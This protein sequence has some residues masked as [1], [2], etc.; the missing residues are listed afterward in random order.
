MTR[1][2][3]LS[4]TT[5]ALLAAACNDMPSTSGLATQL[6]FTVQP[7]S[8]E[9]GAPITVE[10]T[11]QDTEGRTVTDYAGDVTLTL[12]A[13]PA[14]GALSGTLTVAAV[15]GVATF[16]DVSIAKAGTSYQLQA[17]SGTIASAL[18]VPFS[19]T[20]APASQLAFTVQP[21]TQTAGATLS[22]AVEVTA[23]DQFGNTAIGRC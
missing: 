23:L 20:P 2:A 18:S 15:A 21:T 22:P 8:A 3:L 10:V 4:L 19:I 11:A 5:L 6:A 13:N 7:T 14:G 17:A 9:A 1:A 12:G 16:S